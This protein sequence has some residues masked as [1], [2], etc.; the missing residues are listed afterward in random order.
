MYTLNLINIVCKLYLNKAGKK[1]LGG[2][3]GV[4]I[5]LEAKESFT[6]ENKIVVKIWL[7]SGNQEF[8]YLKN[9]HFWQRW[10]QMQRFL[11]KDVLDF[12]SDG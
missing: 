3:V 1:V 12:F 8:R 5:A 6:W 2:H 10:W 7:K 4:A 9:E 11:A